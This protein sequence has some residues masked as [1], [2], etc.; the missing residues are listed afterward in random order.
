MV[1]GVKTKNMYV[2]HKLK[3]KHKNMFFTAVLSNYSVEYSNYWV[4]EQNI[5]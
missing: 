2:Y 4:K 3:N 5:S 1:L